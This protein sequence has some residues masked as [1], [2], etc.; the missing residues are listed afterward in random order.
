M[1]APPEEEAEEEEEEDDEEEEED[2]KVTAEELAS[3]AVSSRPSVHTQ[4]EHN[5][6]LSVL[7]P[8]HIFSELVAKEKSA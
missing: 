8:L 5:L 3:M 6:R 4:V 2:V 7:V 1:E